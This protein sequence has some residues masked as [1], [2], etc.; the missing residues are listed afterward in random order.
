M[1]SVT[2][3]LCVW[4][5]RGGEDKN[6]FL[7]LLMHEGEHEL[8]QTLGDSKGQGGLTCCCPQDLK[9]LDMTRRLNNNMY[10]DIL[11]D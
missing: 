2:C 11:R 6:T 8:G 9:E 5:N 3:Y 10:E 1:T 7:Y 4:K